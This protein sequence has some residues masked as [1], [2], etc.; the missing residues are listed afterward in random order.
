[1][2]ISIFYQRHLACKADKD[3]AKSP[4][5]QHK[6]HENND[7]MVVAELAAKCVFKLY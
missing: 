6:L 2:K 4:I 7:R 5:D 3:N 1:M